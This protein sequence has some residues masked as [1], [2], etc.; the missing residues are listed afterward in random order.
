MLVQ[1]WSFPIIIKCEQVTVE[2]EGVLTVRAGSYQFTGHRPEVV[3]DACPRD[4]EYVPKDMQPGGTVQRGAK[5]L[6]RILYT[7]K[8]DLVISGYDPAHVYEVEFRHTV[9]RSAPVGQV[10]NVDG[11]VSVTHAETSEAEMQT[12][13]TIKLSASVTEWPET[14]FTLKTGSSYE[15]N[16]R[17]DGENSRDTVL[18]QIGNP[19]EFLPSLNILLLDFGNGAL[20]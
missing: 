8:P 18:V 20:K 16:L 15:T 12:P 10:S 7:E 6:Q 14:E 13:I 19:D 5:P 17:K 1:N 9:S 4:I 11:S 2:G 3:R